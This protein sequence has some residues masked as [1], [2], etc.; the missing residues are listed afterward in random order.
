[1]YHEKIKHCV[2][3]PMIEVKSGPVH[4]NAQEGERINLFDFP[5][6]LLHEKD[7]GRYIGTGHLVITNDPDSDWV[8][9]GTYRLM[10]QDRNSAGIYI[11]PGKHGY[12]HKQK[13]FENHRPMPVN[14]VLGNDPLVWFAASCPVPAGMS[15]YNFAGAS[16]SHYSSD[17]Q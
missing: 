11:G 1:M 6:P 14:I 10:L 9:V 8:N 12:L 5:A 2:P 16:E 4:E 7:G 13:Y 15:E 17:S 3:V